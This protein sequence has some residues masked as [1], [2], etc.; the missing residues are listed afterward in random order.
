MIINLDVEIIYM[1]NKCV[2]MD[3]EDDNMT[4]IEF[5]KNSD[6]YCLILIPS[7][8]DTKGGP[9][10][11]IYSQVLY[12]NDEIVDGLFAAGNCASTFTSNLYFGAGTTLS[13]ALIMGYQAGKYCIRNEQIDRN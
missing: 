1:I 2:P 11:N 13:Q 6:I 10:T 8:L 7:L 5:D 3:K 9:D 4:M 12:E